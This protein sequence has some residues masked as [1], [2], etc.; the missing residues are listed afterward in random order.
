[1][2]N[3]FIDTNVIIDF[4][5]NRLPFSIHAAEIFEMALQKKVNVSVSAVS[6][7]N[8]YYILPRTLGHQ[9]TIIRVNKFTSFVTVLD[10]THSVIKK[11]LSSEFNDF[12]DAIQY[13]TAASN[14][15]TEA[16]ITRNNKDFKNSTIPV[17][18]PEA[19]LN[20]F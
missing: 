11:A 20:L 16:I 6:Y 3:L 1:M 14:S 10:V 13:Y 4:L 7:N 18:T 17:Y 12:E 15:K 9:D 19:V 2:K 8:V 5:A